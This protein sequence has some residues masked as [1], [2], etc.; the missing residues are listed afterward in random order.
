MQRR[1]WKKII[2][3]QNKSRR[4]WGV[5]NEILD[6]IKVKPNQELEAN[7]QAEKMVLNRYKKEFA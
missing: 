5:L 7:K 1:I 6:E 2:N 3:T 4:T